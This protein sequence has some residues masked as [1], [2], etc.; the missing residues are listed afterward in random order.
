LDRRWKIHK[1]GGS[2][3]AD[4]GCFRRVAQLMLDRHDAR[5]GVVVSAMGG[6][7]DALLRLA[8]LAEQDD[9]AFNEE[10][11]AI[12]ERYSNTAKELV[13]GEALVG[14]LDA[15]SQDADDLRDVL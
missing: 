11:N 8:A 3:L 2:S 9:D 7:T 1:F 14:V 10:L 4:A 5:T 6:M 15:W 12:G 13:E